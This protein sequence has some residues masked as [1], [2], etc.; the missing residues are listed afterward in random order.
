M[1]TSKGVENTLASEALKQVFNSKCTGI[2]WGINILKLNT[3]FCAL[4]DQNHS[5]QIPAG[6]S[7]CAFCFY[8]VFVYGVS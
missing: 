1:N 5:S 6:L 3:Y 4:L 7:P 8:R 2:P